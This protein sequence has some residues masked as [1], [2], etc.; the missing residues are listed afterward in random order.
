M[1]GADDEAAAAGEDGPGHV[2]RSLER[3]GGE[4]GGRQHRERRPRE[5][6]PVAEGVEHHGAVGPVERV[7]PRGPSGGAGREDVDL[8]P[9]QCS[10]LRP[11][12]LG[13]VVEGRIADGVD[14]AVGVGDP[15]EAEQDLLARRRADGL[16][17]GEPLQEAVGRDPPDA[18]ERQQ[19]DGEQGGGGRHRTGHRGIRGRHVTNPTEPRSRVA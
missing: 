18:V 17:G 7:E 6:R 15:F 16:R 11:G 5:G 14:G 1:G 19:R 9:G 2:L 10:D 3:L 12:R 8:A 13:G 4:R